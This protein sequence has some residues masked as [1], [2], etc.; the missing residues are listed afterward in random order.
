MILSYRNDYKAVGSHKWK[1]FPSN[2]NKK[3]HRMIFSLALIFSLTELKRALDCVMN[4]LNAVPDRKLRDKKHQLISPR[5]IL[6]GLTFQML[7]F[8]KKL[9][10]KRL[11]FGP[12]SFH[13][14]LVSAIQIYFIATFIT[15]RLQAY[16]HGLRFA[17]F[18]SLLYPQNVNMK[19]RPPMPNFHTKI[20]HT[21][22]QPLT[23]KWQRQ[24]T[25]F[26]FYMHDCMMGLWQ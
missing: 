11:C 22:T 10:S 5:W 17:H 4:I 14:P 7:R 20:L 23:A 3:S 8:A 13:S 24:L 21:R 9:H 6:Q 12:L 2:N 25:C 16:I 18:I 19:G 1:V 15:T 26:A